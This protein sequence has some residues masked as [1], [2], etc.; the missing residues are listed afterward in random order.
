MTLHMAFLQLNNGTFPLNSTLKA[1]EFRQVTGRYGVVLAQLST[2]QS[3][4]KPLAT[5]SP[6]H[7]SGMVKSVS[8]LQHAGRLC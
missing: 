3:G 2:H 5:S 4:V 6:A 1:P 8:K 7:L